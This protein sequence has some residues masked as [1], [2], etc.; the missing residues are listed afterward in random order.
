[1]SFPSQNIYQ[2]N[3]NCRRSSQNSIGIQRIDSETLK[4][5]FR[6]TF[7][8]AHLL[9]GNIKRQHSKTGVRQILQK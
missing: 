1:M 4:Q 5:G 9:C 7:G 2:T 8:H 3:I 6:F